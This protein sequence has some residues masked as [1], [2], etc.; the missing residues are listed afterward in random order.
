MLNFLSD[1]VLGCIA[2][3]LMV[4]NS[5]FWGL[6]IVLVALIKLALPFAGIRKLVDPL[7]IGFAENWI[8]G[9][10]VWMRLTQKTE[11][12]VTGIENLNR[13]GWYLVNANHQSWVDIFVLQKL[14]N[15]KIPLLKFFLKAELIKVPVMGFAWWAL[16]FPFMKRYSK[17]YLRKHP[18]KKGKD[19]ETTRRVCEKFSHT[20][21]SVMSF[22]EGTRFSGEKQKSQRSPYTYLLKPKSGG[23]AFAMSVLGEKFHSFLNI[24]IVY[25][26]GVPTFWDFLSGRLHRVVVNVE[27]IEIPEQILAGN[28]EKDKR[29]RSVFHQWIG[30]IWEEKDQLIGRLLSESIA[31]STGSKPHHSAM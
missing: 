8:D 10:K 11:W 30:S 15:R 3:L 7:L 9:N 2:F 13:R 29:F 12:Q 16:D 31:E 28:Y 18:E 1:P 24:T 22:L 20:P 14:F 27:E 21:T 17:T 23:I 5:I 25:P 26:D 19:I 6:V 4:I